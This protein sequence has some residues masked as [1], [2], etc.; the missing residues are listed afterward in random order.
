MNKAAIIAVV[1]Q[2]SGLT[3]T[4]CSRV[5]DCLVDAILQNMGQPDGVVMPGLGKFK[6]VQRKA[7]VARNPIGRA[8]V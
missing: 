8:H 7:R 4:E 1:A 2:K 3:K 6:V 5:V